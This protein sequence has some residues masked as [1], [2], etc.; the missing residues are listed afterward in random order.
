MIEY[1][2]GCEILV[3]VSFHSTNGVSSCECAGVP[4]IVG[5]PKTKIKKKFKIF[6][7]ISP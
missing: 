5:L 2:Y 6:S 1:V 4:F 7:E 3:F